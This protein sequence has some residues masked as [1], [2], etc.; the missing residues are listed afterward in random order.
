VRYLK[1][2]PS[3]KGCLRVDSRK[4][5]ELL[6]FL[7]PAAI[8]VFLFFLLP[9]ILT[10]YISFTPM[11]D[12]N[13]QRYLTQLSGLSNY[14]RLIYMVQHDPDMQGVLITTAVFIGLTL[15][16]NVFGG[17]GL[18]LA[19]Y[20]MEEK[21]SILSQI[22]WLLPRMTPVAVYSLLW[23]YFFHGTDLGIMN[24][25][26]MALGIIHHPISLGNDPF[27]QPWGA[28]T[29]IIFVN[30]L[31]GVSYGMIIFFSAF[32]SIPRELIIAARVD[33]ASTLRVIKDVLIPL[34]KWHIT[35]VVVWQLLSL[36]TT[37]EHIFL[38]VDWRIVNPTYGQTWALYIFRTAFSTVKD[39]GLAAAG[40]TV[41]SV[42]GI[43]LGFLA[44]S[45]LGYKK[46][47]LEPKGDI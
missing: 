31:V 18:A 43:G 37:Y 21:P 30:G 1:R 32:R 33:G 25:I 41:L 46:M 11:K 3:L 36:L 8:I 14:E 13:V 4:T 16:I 5:K 6:F 12:W 15:I 29:I 17:L 44:L 42:I 28:W 24:N 27:L 39:Q 47:I 26:L 2:G 20:F 22:L 10:V 9:L 23:Y 19:T 38:L 7:G 34:T 35:F 45:I 40:A